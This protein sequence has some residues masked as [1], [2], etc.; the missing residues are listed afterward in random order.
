MPLISKND[1]ILAAHL[2]RLGLRFT[3]DLLM[4][5]LG[6]NKMN[7]LYEKLSGKQGLDFLDA[8]L[9]ELNIRYI[10]APDDLNHIPASGSFITVSNH[11]FG[12]L[13]GMLLIRI[14][15]QK[16]PDYKVMAN[17]LLQ[18]AEPVRHYFIS[19]DPFEGQNRKR[20]G[21]N[22]RGLKDA[23]QHLKSGAPLGIFPAGEVSTFQNGFRNIGDKEW[24][25][26]II[27]FIKKAEQPVVPIYFHGSNRLIFHL[28]GKIHPALRTASLPSE[29]F[30]QRGEIKIRIG[31]PVSA[32]EQQ[33]FTVEQ[34]GKF[35]RA[36]VYA[37][38]R[39]LSEKK[40]L[41]QKLLQLKKPQKII[42]PL[43]VQRLR[44][45]ID[46]LQ[47][48]KLQ[49]KDH[50][51]VYLAPSS[52]IPN[53]L[54]EI[55]RLRETTYRAAGE[56]TNKS[57]DLDDFDKYYEHLFLWDRKNEKIAGAYRIGKGDEIFMS[58]GIKGFY[59]STLFHYDE[60]FTPYLKGCLELGRSFVI[61]EYQ[62]KTFPLFLLWKSIV[63]FLQQHPQYRYLL[64]P[65]SISSS[66]SELSRS[67]IIQFIKRFYYDAALAQLVH[68]RRAYQVN[69]RDE[70]GIILDTFSDNL[71][72]LDRLIADIEPSRFRIPVLLKK[73]I[74]QNARIIGF[75]LDPKFNNALDGLMILD[76]KNLPESNAYRL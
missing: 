76:L 3:A 34:L 53:I 41:Q 20:Q 39:P 25:L 30:H 8:A 64:G 44:E 61:E 10:V 42:D 12:I 18:R 27:K 26:S 40:T 56:G 23:L 46:N 24:P 63:Q 2:D 16:R 35:L 11:P 52:S 17:F 6:L 68:A 70:L 36:K 4:Q 19:V 32:W 43:P 73:Y 14:I 7:R 71:N 49:V 65:V 60:A 22:I 50:L 37:L 38:G 28:L 55:G 33:K 15:S 69:E 9:K 13:D 75:N 51:E 5:A 72:E 66:Y 31:H 67:L 54:K 57:V 62:K 58:Y 29:V 1:I 45:E 48:R 74:R 47:N 21:R 59:T